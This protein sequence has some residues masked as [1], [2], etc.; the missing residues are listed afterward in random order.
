[1][2]HRTAQHSLSSTK[3]LFRLLLCLTPV[4][5]VLVKANS[6]EKDCLLITNNVNEN[7][8]AHDYPKSIE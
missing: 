4:Y 1:M 8:S 7:R 5:C 2:S 6:P 3:S